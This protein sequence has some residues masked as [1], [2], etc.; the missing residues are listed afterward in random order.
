M[1]KFFFPFQN[2]FLNAEARLVFLFGGFPQPRSADALTSTPTEE[3]REPEAPH[4]EDAGTTTQGA[5]ALEAAQERFTQMSFEEKVRHT[6]E[7]ATRQL[8]TTLPSGIPEQVLQALRTNI[9]TYGEGIRTRLQDIETWRNAHL[10]PHP[11]TTNSTRSSR[12]EFANSVRQF[13]E[14]IIDQYGSFEN[15]RRAEG[16]NPLTFIQRLTDLMVKIN[17]TTNNKTDSLT[18]NTGKDNI[19]K[20]VVPFLTRDKN[21]STKSTK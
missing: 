6:M 17:S 16:I 11:E 15:L 5:A 9:Q 12:R 18:A 20:K 14:R 10:H 19:N 2:K 8:E 21:D 13:R 1:A 7:M 3:G 4:E